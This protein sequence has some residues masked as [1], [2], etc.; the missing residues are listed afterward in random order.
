MLPSKLPIVIPNTYLNGGWTGIT[1]SWT[2][3]N[4]VPPPITSTD[5]NPTIN[6]V[7]GGTY[8]VTFSVTD[9]FGTH[10]ITKTAYVFVAPGAPVAA[11]ISGVQNSGNFG[12]PISRVQFN[13]IDNNI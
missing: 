10:S 4:G 8:D 12:Y 1:F 6:F 11:C 9:G 5:Q 3:D 7:N 2:F 13:T